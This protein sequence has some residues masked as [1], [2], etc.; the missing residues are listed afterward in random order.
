[1]EGSTT[2]DHDEHEQSRGFVGHRIDTHV[3]HFGADCEQ[4]VVTTLDID[5]KLP[6]ERSVPRDQLAFNDTT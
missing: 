2:Q 4:L 5:A 1:M 3:G 6:L